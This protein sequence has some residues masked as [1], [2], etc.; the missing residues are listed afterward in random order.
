MWISGTGVN[1]A[2]RNSIT[3]LL[4]GHGVWRVPRPGV[5]APIADN[6]RQASTVFRNCHR[7]T[8]MD[9][10]EKSVHFLAGHDVFSG[11]FDEE[12]M[13]VAKDR[14]L[15]FSLSFYGDRV[16]FGVDQVRGADDSPGKKS[17]LARV[18]A[19]NAAVTSFL[20][21]DPR[22]LLAAKHLLEAARNSTRQLQ[23][24][25][26]IRDGRMRYRSARLLAGAVSALTGVPLEQVVNI[27]LFPP[28]SIE[29]GFRAFQAS[30]NEESRRIIGFLASWAEL[31]SLRMP[32]FQNGLDTKFEPFFLVLFIGPSGNPGFKSRIAD[33]YIVAPLPFLSQLIHQ[34][35]DLVG[36]G[37]TETF[38][39][40]I[41]G[42]SLGKINGDSLGKIRYGLVKSVP[43]PY[44]EASPHWRHQ[45][46]QRFITLPHSGFV[47][48][49]AVECGIPPPV[50]SL[51][52]GRPY[53]PWRA[54]LNYACVSAETIAAAFVAVQ[55]VLFGE[56]GISR[57]TRITVAKNMP[58][59]AGLLRDRQIGPPGLP[60]LE[61]LGP[62][63][64][65]AAKT[66]DWLPIKAAQ[67]DRLIRIFG[68]RY[69]SEIPNP[70]NHL[71]DEQKVFR[72]EDKNLGGRAFP[73]LLPVPEDLR[74]FLAEG[75]WSF[76]PSRIGVPKSAK[77]EVERIRAFRGDRNGGRKAFYS[78][79]LARGLGDE[80]I[81][82]LFGHGFALTKA[83]GPISPLP[84][85]WFLFEAQGVVDQVAQQAGLKASIDRLKPPSVHQLKRAKL[86]EAG[87]KSKERKIL[88]WAELPGTI[89]HLP[90]PKADELEFLKSLLNVIETSWNEFRRHPEQLKKVLY[91]LLILGGVPLNHV[92]AYV[93]Y[94]R[95]NSVVR[96]KI[97]GKAAYFVIFPIPQ[98]DQGLGL[99]P[100]RL[101][102]RIGRLLFLT[103]RCIYV[104]ERKN[105][106]I[107]ADKCRFEHRIVLRG[108][109]RHGDDEM[110]RFAR[111]LVR[112]CSDVRTEVWVRN[113]LTTGSKFLARS[114]FGGLIFGSLSGRGIKPCNFFDIQDL[115]F[116]VFGAGVLLTTVTG[117]IWKNVFLPGP[118]DI[119]KYRSYQRMV[120]SSGRGRPSTAQFPA[121][122]L[123]SIEGLTEYFRGAHRFPDSGQICK[124]I[125]Y[126]G[127]YTSKAA[128]N[129]GSPEYR[130]SSLSTA[131][132]IMKSLR[133]QGKLFT[134]RAEH[135]LWP[136]HTLLFL[137][138]FEEILAK[139]A[140]PDQKRS[141]LW[142]ATLALLVG[143][144]AN[145]AALILEQHIDS[146]ANPRIVRINGNK[147]DAASR[148][149]HLGLFSSDPV[150]EA[151]LERFL[152]Q[153]NGRWIPADRN[154]P[155]R[156]EAFQRSVNEWVHEAY[157]VVRADLGMSE[158]SFTFTLQSLRHACAFRAVQQ[159]IYRAL[160]TGT[161]WI[162]LASVSQALGHQSMVTTLSSYLG[163]SML[164]LKWPSL[165]G[166]S[167]G[168]T[169]LG[170]PLPDLL[171]R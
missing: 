115:F 62:V 114:R 149:V 74:R 103:L 104:G 37:A 105:R 128:S 129:N 160:W 76:G 159:A 79:C 59:G 65:M 136:R 8:A 23:A 86:A 42:D 45:I 134:G 16:G 126:F 28:E 11:A 63:G 15:E 26:P 95:G 91:L 152:I 27:A 43:N 46:F 68:R 138:K 3:S 53:G 60:T 33:Q 64:Q 85:C 118:R 29:A 66:C 169:P 88:S 102:D 92:Q 122:G 20:A 139:S 13:D 137:E 157:N 101:S 142:W 49:A 120:N 90:I 87:S 170:S 2:S 107:A 35:R 30:G 71:I 97:S 14:D 4:S 166:D 70:A 119:S 171:E 38:A 84:W 73:R 61:E 154:F 34:V 80:M 48:A 168:Y 116:Q 72:F 94:L 99:V 112:R 83:L 21:P 52:I 123:C 151:L 165:R 145:E 25:F 18:H 9:L 17:P 111:S 132:L 51:M 55:S 106:A 54:S 124:Q 57:S 156:G 93:R 41:S 167:E 140:K 24:K 82:F 69:S 127:C 10:I 31:G 108:F 121:M 96:S 146:L 148:T 75:D 67:T 125:E 163:T 100:L 47:Y 32:C 40:T 5:S 158:T 130:R 98:Q 161:L 144:R 113:V 56:T 36:Q 150:G 39:T 141:A 162:Q 22:G 117:G 44:G 58:V 77:Q 131:R 153:G 78:E 50:L 164:C 155:I 12:Q 89:Q 109:N 81:S 133:N 143:C 6:T 110:I 147:T 19:V 135:L 1:V 7:A